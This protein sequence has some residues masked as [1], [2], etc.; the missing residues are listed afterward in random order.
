M[1]GTLTRRG[2]ARLTAILTWYRSKDSELLCSLILWFSW[3]FLVFNSSLIFRSA[4]ICFLGT[5]G[6]LVF[7]FS[8]CW[9]NSKLALFLCCQIIVSSCLQATM[10]RSIFD[11]LILQSWLLGM[12]KMLV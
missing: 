12:S 6:S 11:S 4:V 10:I 8:G 3:P 2:T 9:H 7:W 1:E 5:L